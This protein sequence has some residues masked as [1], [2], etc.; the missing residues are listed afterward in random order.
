MQAPAISIL[1]QKPL[2]KLKK[3]SGLSWLVGAKNFYIHT[4]LSSALLEALPRHFEKTRQKLVV[5][6]TFKIL[7]VPTCQ[8][9]AKYQ[10]LRYLGSG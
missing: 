7:Q 4:A 10:G 1:N 9:A 5:I 6:S 8:T 3:P 2:W